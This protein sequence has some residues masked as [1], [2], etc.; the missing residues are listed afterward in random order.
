MTDPHEDSGRRLVDEY[1]SRL[2]VHVEQEL[3]SGVSPIELI[4][5][6]TETLANIGVAIL[7]APMT[8]DLFEHIAAETKRL[9]T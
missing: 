8:I 6:M 3:K 4:A 5:G 9:A 1:K 2:R 7:G